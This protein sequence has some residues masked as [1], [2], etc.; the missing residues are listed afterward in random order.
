MRSGFFCCLL[1][2]A[3]LASSATRADE[4]AAVNMDGGWV[5]IN[6]WA[7][8]VG[9]IYAPLNYTNEAAAQEFVVSKGGTLTTITASVDNFIGGDP[10]IV[11][12]FTAVNRRPGALLGRVSVPDSQINGFNVNGNPLNTFD[13]SSLGIPLVAG[14]NYIVTFTVAI[15]GAVRYR[16][17]LN[18]PNVNSF[19][20]P[21]LRSPNGGLTWTVNSVTPEIGLV[22]SVIVPSPP[23]PPVTFEVAI[24]VVPGTTDNFVNLNSK[25]SKPV[26]VAVFGDADF[27]VDDV[28]LGSIVLG[29]PALIASGDG[30][31]VAPYTISV[32]DVDG[33]GHDDLLLEFDTAELKA[34]GA[35][36]S[37]STEVRLEADL[38]NGDSIFG[39]DSVA[40]SQPKGG[41][42]GNGI[43]GGKK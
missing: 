9:D 3:A 6:G 43:G 4:I 15:P 1:G 16:A 24:D 25:K 2:L 13:L 28:V 42:K 40:T 7:T 20:I 23:P 31:P 10:L 37:A 18:A 21:S 38:T 33:D 14:Q 27:S 5:G 29:D 11:S 36:D 39:S 26:P 19:G 34:V 22:V 12:V 35:I 17:I 30:V 8:Y 41:G 32:L